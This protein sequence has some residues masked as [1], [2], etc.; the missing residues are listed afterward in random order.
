M[1]LANGYR[2]KRITEV[3]GGRVAHYEMSVSLSIL[4]SVSAAEAYTSR[5]RW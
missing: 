1:Y 3:D 4:I 5:L 2:I